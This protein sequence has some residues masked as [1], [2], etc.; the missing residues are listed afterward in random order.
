M[1]SIVDILNSGVHIPVPLAFYYTKGT[2]LNA[3]LPIILQ[4][5][6][7]KGDGSGELI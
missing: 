2:V 3:S 6:N 5:N 7:M 1:V 4:K